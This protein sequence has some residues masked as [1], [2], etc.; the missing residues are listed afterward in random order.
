MIGEGYSRGPP[1]SIRLLS[2]LRYR[3]I[4]NIPEDRHFFGT[5]GH[6]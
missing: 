5:I 3:E 1:K 2:V 4:L 6:D